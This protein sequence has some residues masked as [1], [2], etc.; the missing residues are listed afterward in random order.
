MANRVV[1][2]LGR[3]ALALAG[4]AVLTAPGLAQDTTG[5]NLNAAGRGTPGGPAQLALAQ[6]LYALGVAQKDALTVLTAAR[7]AAAVVPKD[8]D[9]KK[10]TRPTEGVSVTQ[11]G[12]GVDAPPGLAEMLAAARDL[13]GGDETLLGL[14]DDAEAEGARGGIGGAAQTLSRLDAGE[15]DVWEIAYYGNSLAE[16]AVIGDGDS[17][18]DLVI[19][20]ENGNTICTE[21]SASDKAY[22]DW[23][24]SW[25]GYFTA[26]VSNAGEARNSY[27]LITN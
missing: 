12:E 2:G 27:Y 16:L 26:T 23:M 9:Q 18:L 11:T 6:D 25:N 24:P 1:I 10:T 3:V 21:L 8:V 13:A 22:C 19:T 7:L 17:N 5:R 15:T 4:V 14:I 20:D